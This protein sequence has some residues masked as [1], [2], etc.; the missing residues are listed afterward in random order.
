MILKLRFYQFFFDYLS[1]FHFIKPIFND[2][3]L[4]FNASQYKFIEFL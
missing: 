3:K 1:I 4:I 2:F